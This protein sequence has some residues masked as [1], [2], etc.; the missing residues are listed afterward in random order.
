[1]RHVDV[2]VTLQESTVIVE[3][4]NMTGVTEARVSEQYR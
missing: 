2:G 3:Q 4:Y 1:M